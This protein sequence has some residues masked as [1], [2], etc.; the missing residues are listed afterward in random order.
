M[1][2]IILEGVKSKSALVGYFGISS[3]EGVMGA[4]VLATYQYNHTCNGISSSGKISKDTDFHVLLLSWICVLANDINNEYENYLWIFRVLTTHT[5]VTPMT[6]LILLCLFVLVFKS[7]VFFFSIVLQSTN[8]DC[9][10]SVGNWCS[11]FC[12]CY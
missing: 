7:V 2:A 8:I 11:A 10:L 3:R 5:P 4:D 6:Y 1:F 12:C 9:S